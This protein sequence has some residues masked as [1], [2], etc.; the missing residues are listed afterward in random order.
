MIGRVVKVESTQAAETEDTFEGVEKSRFHFAHAE[1]IAPLAA[2]LGLHGSPGVCTVD[3]Q[4]VRRPVFLTH[5]RLAT[6]RQK[7]EAAHRR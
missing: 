1:T 6:F 2:L 7:A 3:A 5:P 4:P